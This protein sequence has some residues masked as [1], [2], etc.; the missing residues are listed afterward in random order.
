[1]S[2]QPETFLATAQQCRDPESRV[3]SQQLSLAQRLLALRTGETENSGLQDLQE[4]L[5]H[6]QCVLDHI[7]IKISEAKGEAVS[8]IQCF[9]GRL[10]DIVVGMTHFGRVI[11]PE[12]VS[13]SSEI[14]PKGMS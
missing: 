1:M 3:G 14:A 11:D 6:C 8:L 10:H 2:S 7:S 12:N 5:R 13:S 4:L 9:G